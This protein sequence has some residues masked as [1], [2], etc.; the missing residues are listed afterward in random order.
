MIVDAFKD[1]RPAAFGYVP[2][3][4]AFG[5]LFQSLQLNWIYGF[6]MSFLVYAGSAQ[7]IAI[8]L[9]ANHGSLLSLAIATFLVN[10]RHIFY[11]LSFLDKFK[12]NNFI[13]YYLIFGLT[14]E[15]YSIICSKNTYAD[16]KYEIYVVFMCHFY[17]V[18]GTFFGI[19]LYSQLM[20]INIQFLFF[21]LVALFAILTVDSFKVNKD[22]FL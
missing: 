3:G 20:D 7:F 21:T 9:L 19:L 6:L 12:F 10:L 1:S 22:F 17:W 8:P 4:M 14:D 16:P 15:S 13:K 5:I 11:G 18:L 2:L